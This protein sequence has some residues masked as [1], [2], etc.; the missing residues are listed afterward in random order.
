MSLFLLPR[1]EIAFLFE[2]ID[3]LSVA[4]VSR[5]CKYLHKIFLEAR[6]REPNELQF[7][8]GIS[9]PGY[10]Q[11]PGTRDLKKRITATFL[12]CDGSVARPNI[13]VDIVFDVDLEGPVIFEE[14]EVVI[15]I[16]Q[17]SRGRFFVQP[18]KATSCEKLFEVLFYFFKAHLPLRHIVFNTTSA[19][20]VQTVSKWIYSEGRRCNRV[21]FRRE[22]SYR[23]TQ[24]RAFLGLS[25]AWNDEDGTAL[26]MECL[27]QT[28]PL[29]T[30]IDFTANFSPEHMAKLSKFVRRFAASSVVHVS[31]NEDELLQWSPNRFE[32]YEVF[33]SDGTH[34][35]ERTVL[36][37]IS[38]QKR[39]PG[40]RLSVNLPAY[41]PENIYDAL[42]SSGTINEEQPIE[43][44][45]EF[46]TT[47]LRTDKKRMMLKF[48]LRSVDGVGIFFYP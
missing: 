17:L 40:D 10:G 11:A 26:V 21:I 5:T 23:N 37:W 6:L 39:A 7:S 46:T 35:S 34:I 13:S 33:Q 27:Q 3:R 18:S 36:E 1:Q 41:G 22:G 48:W 38:S 44:P 8:F 4:R 28:Q 47:F 14:G 43:A 12:H 29:S 24:I 2:F 15:R 25:T 9:K 42:K 32:V 45:G 30:F 31:M 20:V 16:K 19:A